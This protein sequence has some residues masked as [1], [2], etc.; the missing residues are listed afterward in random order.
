[1][2]LSADQEAMLEK[3]RLLSADDQEFLQDLASK[4]L[5]GEIDSQEFVNR[6]KDQKKISI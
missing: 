4:L 2:V 5:S 1:M 3:Y 6:L